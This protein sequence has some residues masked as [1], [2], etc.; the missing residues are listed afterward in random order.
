MLITSC[1]SLKF[2]LI[3]SSCWQY[4]QFVRWVWPTDPKGNKV[5]WSQQLACLIQKAAWVEC[6]WLLPHCRVSMDGPQVCD[7]HSS[8][9]DSK[10][11]ELYMRKIHI[12]QN[13]STT[14][15]IILIAWWMRYPGV[16]QYSAWIH[17]LAVKTNSSSFKL[18]SCKFR[19]TL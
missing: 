5:L 18:Y 12:E 15:G 19:C 6:V 13:Q 7:D 4:D 1:Y 2:Y 17:F 16:L 14:Y 3:L 11:S 10:A 9:G 8:F